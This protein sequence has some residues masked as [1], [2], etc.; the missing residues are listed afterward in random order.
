MAYLYLLTAIIGEVIATSAL[1]SSNQFTRLIPSVVV[2]TGYATAFYFLSVTL[3]YI[4]IGVAYA[5]WAG[6]GILLVMLF[7]IIVYRQIPDI[8]SIIGALLIISGVMVINLFS[9]TSVH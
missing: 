1:K 3:N 5:I 9:N 2:F 8:A 4:P 7:G 6:A